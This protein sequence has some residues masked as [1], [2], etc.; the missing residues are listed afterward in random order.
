MDSGDLGSQAL[1]EVIMVSMVLRLEYQWAKTLD[2]QAD[3]VISPMEE[4]EY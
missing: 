1:V 3:D 2:S 4:G